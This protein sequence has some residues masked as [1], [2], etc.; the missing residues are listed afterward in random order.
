MVFDFLFRW[1]IRTANQFIDWLPVVDYEVTYDMLVGFGEFLNMACYF[2]PVDT[3]K[4]IVTVLIMEEGL[5]I[6]VAIIKFI[7]K[8]IPFMG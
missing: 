4:F 1:L 8:F 3:I 6:V 5:R 7:L 2:V